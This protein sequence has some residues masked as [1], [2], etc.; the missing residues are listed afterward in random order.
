MTVTDFLLNLVPFSQE[1]LN[2]IMLHFEEEKVKKN[3]L[4]LKEG[5][6]CNKLYFI[7][8]G[9]SRSYYLK[10]DG[11]EV[12]QWFFGEGQFMSSADSFFNQTASF[13]NLEILEDSIL[14]SIT[15]EKMEFLLAKYHKMEKCIRLL[16]IEMF[17]T[18]I[19]KMNATQ[20]H[21]A[22]EKYDYM[23]SEFPNIAHRIS[24]GHIASYLGMTQETLSRIRKN[25]SLKKK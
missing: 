24:L 1:E 3:E 16:S 4:L 21:T 18:L 11:K 6:I 8:E 13:Y 19:R 17:T 2:D 25:E 9:M 5:K 23:I 22:K 7:Q 10:E 14:Y 12:T 15:F 20:F